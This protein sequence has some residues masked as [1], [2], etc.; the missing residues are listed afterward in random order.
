MSAHRFVGKRILVGLT[1]LDAAGLVREQVREQVQWHGLIG[2]VGD[3]TLVFEKSDGSGA[4]SIPFDGELDAADP[5]A[6]YTLRSTGEAVT[7]VDFLASF[8]IHSP[9]QR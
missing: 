1:Y 6:V 9:P 3:H 8:T 4:F 2:D 7:A 5:A